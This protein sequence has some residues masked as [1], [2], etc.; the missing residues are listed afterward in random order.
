MSA[1]QGSTGSVDRSREKESRHLWVGGLPDKIDE[2]GIR[3]YFTRFIV[4]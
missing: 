3:D 2:A 1:Q 4:A